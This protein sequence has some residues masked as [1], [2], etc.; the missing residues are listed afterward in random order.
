M[1]PVTQTK[2][3]TED[4]NGNCMC[5]A[6]ASILEID[7]EKV[8]HFEDMPECGKGTPKSPSWWKALNTWLYELGY[9]LIIFT[10]NQYI[11]GY[12]IANGTSPRGFEHAVVYEG[13]AMV[14]DPHPV[15]GGIKEVTSKWVLVPFNPAGNQ[16]GG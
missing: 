7:L 4:Q 11:T 1:K 15:G 13:P 12:Y 2:L 14:H 6:F 10:D 5:A 9:Q 8:P 3:H 16:K